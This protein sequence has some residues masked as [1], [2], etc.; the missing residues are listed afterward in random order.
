MSDPG[1]RHALSA[2]AAMSTSKTGRPSSIPVAVGS[3]TGCEGGA[4]TGGNL[5]GSGPSSA[6]VLPSSAADTGAVRGTVRVGVARGC[7]TGALV[8]GGWAAGGL[9]GAPRSRGVYS[10]V[11]DGPGCEAGDE[12]LRNEIYIQ[13]ETENGGQTFLGRGVRI[14]CRR[15]AWPEERWERRHKGRVGYAP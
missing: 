13:E 2:S 11:N 8:G 7:E 1:R 14:A 10:V 6:L 15:S 3:I 12:A 5:L 9:A 4:A